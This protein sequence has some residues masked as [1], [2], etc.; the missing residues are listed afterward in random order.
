MI[1]K[2]ETYVITT[3]NLDAYDRLT[4]TSVLDLCQSIASNHANELGIGYDEF[5]KENKQWLIIGNKFTFLKDLVSPYKIV[6][7]TFPLKSNT[8]H[9]DRDYYI[10]SQDDE[11]IVKGSSK[12]V[13]YDANK[14]RICLSN[15]ILENE[16][17]NTLRVYENTISKIDMGNLEEYN[18]VLSHIV[19]FTDL[20]HYKH[21][22]NTRYF[23][24]FYDAHPLSENEQIQEIQIDYIEQCF[25]NEQVDVYQKVVDN[26]IYL[27]G[28]V[29]EKIV[30]NIKVTLSNR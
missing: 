17:L 16:E 26:E 25:L 11:L 30:F 19:R 4:V 10:Y 9:C 18:H 12:W 7:E 20:D 5:I 29:N 28:K 6:I 1:S 23:N 13:I 2:K 15:K 3:N 27:F 21:F 8:F 14:K 24:L 22:N